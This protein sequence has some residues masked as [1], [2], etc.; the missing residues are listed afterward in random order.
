MSQFAIGC[1]PESEIHAIC[2]VSKTSKLLRNR[3]YHPASTLPTQIVAMLHPFF[4]FFLKQRFGSSFAGERLYFT[5]LAESSF[6]LRAAL[7]WHSTTPRLIRATG[8]AP[9]FRSDDVI[10]DQ[11]K[12]PWISLIATWCAQ[13]WRFLLNKKFRDKNQ[14]G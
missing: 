8:A 13:R 7:W 4:L 5:A 2:S 1:N 10:C 14:F 3:A 12:R 6:G 9:V 11:G